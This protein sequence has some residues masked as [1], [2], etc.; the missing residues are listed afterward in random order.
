M[1]ATILDGAEIGAR[2]VIGANA[3]VTQ[4]TKIP[5]GSLVLGAP[6]KVRRTLDLEEQSG[7]RYWAE[8]YVLLTRAYIFRRTQPAPLG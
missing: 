5:P 4:G 8:K 1:G 6:A 7:V 3:L 2:S